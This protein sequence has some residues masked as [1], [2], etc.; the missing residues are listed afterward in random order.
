MKEIAW[1]E[2]LRI[3]RDIALDKEANQNN[4]SNT[5]SEFYQIITREFPGYKL[6]RWTVRF[7]LAHELLNVL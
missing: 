1:N 5:L 6:S 3:Q 7:K 4:S 2:A